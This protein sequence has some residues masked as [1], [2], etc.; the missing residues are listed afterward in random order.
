[1]ESSAKFEIDNMKS[2][3]DYMRNLI[4]LTL[5]IH[6]TFDPLFCHG[7]IIESILKE[8]LP[9]LRQF[10]YTMTHQ[11]TGPML[12][13]EF[14]QWPMNVTFYGEERSRWIHIYSL[15]W[16]AN[17]NDQRR[18]PIVRIE[19]QQSVSSEV[20]RYEY[21]G[22]AI[23]TEGDDFSSLDTEFRYSYQMLTSIPID[24]QLPLRIHKLILSRELRKYL[25]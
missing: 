2:I 13:E 24:I 14:R 12:I 10:H 6:D 22:Y 16:P 15:P 1:L 25:L 19:S 23:I 9:Y 21:R 20:K 5:S 8:Y 11:M 4:V 7:P 18:L 3:L 17:K